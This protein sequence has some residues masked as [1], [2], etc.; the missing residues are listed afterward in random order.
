[1]QKSLSVCAFW[2]ASSIPYNIRRGSRRGRAEFRA[3]KRPFREE[4]R[5]FCHGNHEVPF[6]LVGFFQ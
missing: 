5:G 1:M 3:G 4:K 6:F 2:A